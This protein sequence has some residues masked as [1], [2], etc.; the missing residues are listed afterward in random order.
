M[1]SSAFRK[2]VKRLLDEDPEY[3]FRQFSARNGNQSM[4]LDKMSH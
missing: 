4:S 3:G 1:G 2:I